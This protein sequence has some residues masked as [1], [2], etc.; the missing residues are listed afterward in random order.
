MEDCGSVSTCVEKGALSTKSE[1][2]IDSSGGMR[3]C[4]FW[5]CAAC[6]GSCWRVDT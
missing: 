4:V 1:A 5:N 3:V 6:V 2:R